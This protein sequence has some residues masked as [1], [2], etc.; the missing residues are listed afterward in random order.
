MVMALSF[1]VEL[2]LL[3]G[4]VGLLG[5]PSVRYRVVV[6]ALIGGVYSGVCFNGGTGITASMAGR[7]ASLIIISL[8]AFGWRITAIK[9]GSLFLLL[10]FALAGAADRSPDPGGMTLLVCAGMICFLCRNL[11]R[12]DMS[13]KMYSDVQ[14]RH[15]GKTISL[16]ALRDTGN[17]LFDPISGEPVIVI[18]PEP[19]SVLLGLSREELADPVETLRR[20]HIR[21][22][23]L[24]PYSS[25]GNEKGLMLAMRFAD[26]CVDGKKRSVVVAMAPDGM[27][28]HDALIGG[29]YDHW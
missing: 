3:V 10:S 1:A 4:V 24:V 22:L 23:R 28:G 17:M 2:L 27:G 29:H 26:A 13:G 18:G 7:L 9:A 25:V 14:I 16:M 8:I 15:G 12:N 11:W 5:I 6:A 20:H 21:G 19:V